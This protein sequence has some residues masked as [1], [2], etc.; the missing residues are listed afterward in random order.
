MATGATPVP[1]TDFLQLRYSRTI[2]LLIDLQQSFTV[3]SWRHMV[4]PPPD[5]V[6]AI[7]KAFQQCSLLLRSVPPNQLLILS[8][9]PFMLSSDYYL[10]PK[11]SCL[12]TKKEHKRVV[13]PGNCILDASG[14]ESHLD[15][16]LLSN[17]E[18]DT[19][20][21]GGCTLT[22][23]V[24]VSSCALRRQYADRLRVVVCLEL[25][26]ARD[27]NYTQRCLDCFRKYMDRIEVGDCVECA[28]EGGEKISPVDRAV[29]DMRDAGCVVVS[30]IHFEE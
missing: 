9:C 3:G 11:I 26:G 13:K 12:L 22:S 4:T 6:N 30:R 27:A 7:I 25:C 10:D 21:I 17:P 23:C 14:F 28:K 15:S 18:I 8:Q 16:L 5:G 24:R 2:L 29:R 19:I 1:G 20:L